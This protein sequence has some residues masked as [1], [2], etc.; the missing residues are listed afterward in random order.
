MGP[1]SHGTF[2]IVPVKKT[3]FLVVL[4]NIC[5]TGTLVVTALCAFTQ[6]LFNNT[7]VFKKYSCFSTSVLISLE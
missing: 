4:V 5:R 1:Y 6:F 7:S 2:L 3:R